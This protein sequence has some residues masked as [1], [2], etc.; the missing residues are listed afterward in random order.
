MLKK[1]HE[2][3]KQISSLHMIAG[4]CLAKGKGL[5]A[6][7]AE[8]GKRK[9]RSAG[10]YIAVFLK[11][12]FL[13]GVTGLFGGVI[14]TLFHISVG[15]ATDLRQTHPWIIG[16]LPAGGVVIL[17]L[18]KL[19]RLSEKTGTDHVIGSVREDGKVSPVLAPLIFAGTVITHLFGGSAGREG[20]ALQLGGSIGTVVGKGFRLDEKDMHLITLCGMSAVFSALFGTPLTAA[21]FALEVI[22]VGVIYYSGLIP[23]LASSLTAYG[24]SLFFGVQPVRFTLL[25]IPDL[26]LWTIL[27]T[28]GLA[29]VCAGVS[30][31]FC[32]ALKKTGSWLEKLIPN[33]YLRIAAGG[34]AVIAMTLLVGA[35]DYNGAGMDIVAK[36]IGGS[37]KPEAFALKILFTAITVGAGYKGGEIVPTFFIGATLGCL[38]GGFFGIGAG[39]G[40]AVGMVALFCGVVNCPVASMILG[41]EVFGAQGLL[42]FAVACGV[43]Y[44]LSGYYGIYGSQKI[45]YSKLKAEFINIHT[46]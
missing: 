3:N 41:V 5:A 7:C 18:Y 36:A 24:V 30:I 13:A 29:V 1:N 34:A 26:T 8:K 35:G 22:S 45:I 19:G 32:T 21:L 37:A 17:L 4:R 27:K 20:A 46:K 16:F 10:N 42:F 44:M 38:I 40:A 6:I 23:C 39:F 28:A 15:F 14:G 33:K 11:W 25:S 9:S 12:V 31:L 2:T 43:S